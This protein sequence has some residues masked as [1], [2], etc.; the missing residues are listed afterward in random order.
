M[1]N[2]YVVLRIGECNRQEFLNIAEL[3]LQWNRISADFETVNK[4]VARQQRAK[5]SDFKISFVR[6]MNNIFVNCCNMVEDMTK[7]KSS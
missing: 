7:Y 2:R 5:N 1:Y 3:L 6:Y 4:A